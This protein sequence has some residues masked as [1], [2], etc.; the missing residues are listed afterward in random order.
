MIAFPS[1][2][3]SSLLFMNFYYLIEYINHLSLNVALRN[4]H[5]CLVLNI[6]G[7]LNSYKSAGNS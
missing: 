4:D 1:H 6:Y 5:D 2:N 3:I 7:Q